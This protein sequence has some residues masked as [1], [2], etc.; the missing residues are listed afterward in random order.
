[1]ESEWAAV[2]SSVL[3]GSVL[4]GLIFII[5]IDDLDE[6]VKKALIRKFADDTKLAMKIETPEDA[7]ELQRDLDGI[8][9]W[10]EIWEMR[11]NI[12]KCK[13]MHLGSNN[14]QYE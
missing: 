7:A 1:M 10:A 13:V 4:G 12:D 9:R 5:Y 8:N 14:Q 3:Q 6:A 2:E 11:F